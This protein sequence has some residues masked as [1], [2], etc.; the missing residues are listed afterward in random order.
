LVLVLLWSA[1]AR[2]DEPNQDWAVLLRTRAGAELLRSIPL[3]AVRAQLSAALKPFGG[4]GQLAGA[5]AIGAA[6]A[7]DAGEADLALR[8]RDAVAERALG[9]RAL[10]P[11]EVTLAARRHGDAVVLSGSYRAEATPFAAA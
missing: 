2:A 10:L 6:L 8:I 5:T 4:G 7:K 1:S 9:S 3:D 11:E